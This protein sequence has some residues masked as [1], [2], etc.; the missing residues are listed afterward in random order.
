M[1]DWTKQVRSLLQFARAL[2]ISL[3]L[4]VYPVF[5]SRTEPGRF[6]QQDASTEFFLLS[7]I[8]ASFHLTMGY[9]DV[10][11]DYLRGR[12]LEFDEATG[13]A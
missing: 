13:I 7:L 3:T 6:N 2:S 9:G 12:R 1:P 5:S 11:S 4:T 10:S 8:Q